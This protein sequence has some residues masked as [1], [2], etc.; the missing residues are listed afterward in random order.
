MLKNMTL[1]K[2]TLSIIIVT[3]IILMLVVYTI[4]S[5]ILLNNM[6]QL[7]ETSTQQNVQR[8]LDLLNTETEQLTISASDWGAWDDTYDFIQNP[9]DSYIE[10]NLVES[11]F[12]HLQLDVIALQN[13]NGDVVFIQAVDE[14]NQQALTTE[15]ELQTYLRSDTLLSDHDEY[16]ASTNG[17]MLLDSHPLL[18]ASHP[19]VTSECE[20]PIRGTIIMG[21]FLTWDVVNKLNERANLSATFLQLPEI[22]LL[23]DTERA[24]RK[25]S[26]DNPIVVQELSDYAIVGYAL[27]NDMHNNPILMLR[28]AEQRDYYLQG[29]ISLYSLI[30][31]LLMVSFLFGLIMLR[32]IEKMVLE[33]I[34]TLSD[35]VSD[36]GNKSDFQ[37]RISLPGEDEITH[38]AARINQML[39]ALQEAQQ[40]QHE[41][42]IRYRAVVE[43]QTELIARFLPDGML[44]F[45]NEAMYRY[46]PYFPGTDETTNETM[47]IGKNFLDLIP[48]EERADMRTSLT[49]LTSLHPTSTIEQSI[50]S[51][52]EL[53][54]LQWTNRA[55]YNSMG[56][57]IEIQAVGRDITERKQRE[58]EFTAIATVASALREVPTR[59]RM[60]AV[61][62]DQTSKIIHAEN[63]AIIMEVPGSSGIVVEMANGQW[64]PV[65][66]QRF[67][68][69][70]LFFTEQ[71]D[72]RGMPLIFFPPATAS[73]PLVASG[74]SIGTLCIGRESKL[75]N[76]ELR[77]LTAISDIAATALHR[78]S[79]YEQTEKHLNELTALHAI[80]M[81]IS[82]TLNMSAMLQILLD[83]I[84]VQLSVDGSAIFLYNQHLQ[85]LTYTA[86]RGSDGLAM[87]GTRYRL[88]QGQVGVAALERHIVNLSRRED[89]SWYTEPDYTLYARLKKPYPSTYSIPLIA[90]GEVKGVML[91]FHRKPLDSDPDWPDF[92]EALSSHTAIAIDNA[93]LL[94]DIQRSRDELSLTYDATLEG[95]VRALD[96]RDHETEGH[97]QRVTEMTVRLAQEMGVYGTDLLHIRRGALLHDIGKIG[98]SDS[99]LNKPGPLTDEERAVMCKHPEYAYNMLAPIAY[100][101]PALDIPYC[102]HERWDGTG[103]P[104]QLKGDQIPLGA[105]IFAVIDVWD[106]LRSDR[107]YR[108]AWSEEKVQ[109]H[110]RKGSNTHFDPQVVDAFL[111]LLEKEKEI[112]GEK[113]E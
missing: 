46:F 32:L 19:I 45:V 92:L 90:R 69:S 71:T 26:D 77:I 58:R 67:E 63:V 36:I 60:L 35:N 84:T 61:V 113:E 66:G 79:L 110:L 86:G 38:L 64:E 7:E 62:I 42:E 107:P 40:R 85:I 88:G 54:W 53:Q 100:L 97:S 96:L 50:R 21:R 105:R 98:I 34:S 17:I 23:T 108:K 112:E 49:S 91:F 8:F 9:N 18:I 74:R 103:Y 70:S 31:A 106:A 94:Q 82:S 89:G 81:A 25:M 73:S 59:E 57:M 48:E 39:D 33:R 1:K 29:K 12:E 68:Q 16:C 2:K 20:G 27:V 76:A 55:I 44:T 28:I 72:E 101:R 51:D 5:V 4:M 78:A 80:D 47:L 30:I 111:R 6:R 75:S 13:D 99:I 93:L 37:A 83:Q 22:V 102:H 95:W 24:Y 3:F 87:K 109:A 10:T 56:K 15:Q 104:R 52:G 14:D 41:S 11:T 43:E 65:T